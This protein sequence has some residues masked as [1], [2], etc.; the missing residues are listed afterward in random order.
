[1]SLQANVLGGIFAIA[2]FSVLYIVLQQAYTYDFRPYSIDHGTDSTNL[3]YIDIA[4]TM[5]PVP[6][7]IAFIWG[8]WTS[9]GSSRRVDYVE[10]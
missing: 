4:W 8:L 3:N 5:W 6:L 10:Q 2:A 1:M 7:V 9:T